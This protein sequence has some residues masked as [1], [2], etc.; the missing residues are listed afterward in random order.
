MEKVGKKC[1]Y[2]TTEEKIWMAN[3]HMT[4]CSVLLLIKD[5]QTK[6]IEKY[7]SYSSIDKNY[8]VWQYPVLVKM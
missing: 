6:T 2:V 7:I 8:G 4:M 1:E 5:W 3:K